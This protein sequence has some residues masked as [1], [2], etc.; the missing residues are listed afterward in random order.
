VTRDAE[1]TRSKLLDAATTEF[2]TYGIAGARVDRI[3]E[4]AGVNKRMIYAYFGNKEQL[5]ETVIGRSLEDLVDE[6]PLDEQDLPAY[7]GKLFDYLVAHP[8]RR[9]LALWRQLEGPGLTTREID[10]M[11]EKIARIE[12]ARPQDGRLSGQAVLTF[13]MALVPAWPPPTAGT[14]AELLANQ[15]ADVVESVRRLTTP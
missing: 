1:L 6:V 13:I 4:T 11:Q 9:R 8:E 15:R 14:D 2:A 10:S 5:F 12:R 3:S 7:A